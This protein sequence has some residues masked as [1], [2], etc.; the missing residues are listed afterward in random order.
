MI[1]EKNNVVVHK[2]SRHFKNSVKLSERRPV[3][4][5]TIQDEV[6]IKRKKL[7]KLRNKFQAL[8]TDMRDTQEEFTRERE[9]CLDTIREYKRQIRLR[10]LIIETYIP[11]EEVEKV[12]SRAVWDE[13]KDN[14]G[15][16]PL[17]TADSIGYTRQKRPVSRPESK[18]PIPDLNT[19]MV[20]NLDTFL[21]LLSFLTLVSVTQ[22]FSLLFLENDW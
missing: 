19:L 13:G 15:L 18:R 3:N 8:R 17:D 22:Y 20:S 10:Q 11:P 21:C 2:F 7:A 12:A 6:D 5:K 16:Q 4:I 9:D 14:W 1:A